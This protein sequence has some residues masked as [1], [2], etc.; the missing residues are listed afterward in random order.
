MCPNGSAKIN[1]QHPAKLL[2]ETLKKNKKISTKMS[3][4]RKNHYFQ[5]C[6]I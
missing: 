5:P 6:R 2:Q 1:F 3:N 4:T